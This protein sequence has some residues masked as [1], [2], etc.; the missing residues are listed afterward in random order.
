M[1][2]RRH[3]VVRLAGVQGRHRRQR[4]QVGSARQF[5]Q[6]GERLLQALVDR[7]GRLELGES[8]LR[9]LVARQLGNQ[10]RQVERAVVAVEREVHPSRIDAP[11]VGIGD[12]SHRRDRKCRVEQPDV[13]GTG[14]RHR[15]EPLRLGA[16]PRGIVVRR[17][18]AALVGLRQAPDDL[19][20]LRRGTAVAHPER[21]EVH[22]LIGLLDRVAIV[23]E[24]P[25]AK[26]RVN[27]SFR[28]LANDPS[29]ACLAGGE[30]P[31]RGA[32]QQQ[33]DDEG[34]QAPSRWRAMLCAGDGGRLRTSLG[35]RSTM[36]STMSRMETTPVGRPSSSISGTCR[37]PPT[38]ILFSA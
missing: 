31:S 13:R 33:E 9:R 21:L 4:L 14:R 8:P 34:A 38:L 22:R 18:Q 3:G 27:S 2:Q 37:K 11:D 24:A 28:D 7:E 30:Q 32:R 23:G 29:G 19:H 36:K 1:S 17:G 16:Q 12:V 10:L 20:R 35:K 5:A 15:G 6:T 26:L 25:P